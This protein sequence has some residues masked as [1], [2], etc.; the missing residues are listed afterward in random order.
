MPRE[1]E[2]IVYEYENIYTGETFKTEEEAAQSEDNYLNE[3]GGIFAYDKDGV[4]IS[5]VHDL[6]D[7]SSYACGF[8]EIKAITFE[9][10]KSLERVKNII[11][12][13]EDEMG[14]SHAFIFYYNHFLN[15]PC[16][17]IKNPRWKSGDEDNGVPVFVPAELEVKQLETQLKNIKN[18]LDKIS[19]Q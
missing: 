7:V 11:A 12:T 17:F 18:L 4:K 16:T 14:A 15:F 19:K 5:R 1:I 8:D 9:N 6:I 10:L 3:Y 13:Q 2:T